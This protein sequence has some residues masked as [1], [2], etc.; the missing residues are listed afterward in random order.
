MKYLG[1]DLSLTNT[2]WCILKVVDRKPKVIRY[3]LIQPKSLRDTERIL[4][5]EKEIRRICLTWNIKGVGLEGYALFSRTGKAMDRGELA[6]IVKRY[7]FEVKIPLLII[8]PKSLKKYMT[9]NGNADKDLVIKCAIE[10]S[11]CLFL[12]VIN[13]RRNDI[14][15]AYAVANIALAKAGHI[16]VAGWR[17]DLLEGYSDAV[18]RS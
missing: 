15:D 3:G 18:T 1:L 17:K 8:P 13:S 2:G 12:K 14:A 11:R 4:F 6:G 7:L 5:I 9:G 16:D 10:N